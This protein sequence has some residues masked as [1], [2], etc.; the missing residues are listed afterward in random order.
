M[1]VILN[2]CFGGFHPSTECYELYCKK[3]D[4]SC[5][6][7]DYDWKHHDYV[8]VTE[9]NSLVRYDC[10]TKDFGPFIEGSSDFDS[11]IINLFE[12]HRTD[13]ILIECVEEL[14]EQA[15]SAVSKLVVVEIPDDMDYV[16]DNYDG[17]ETLHENVRTW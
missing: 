10:V 6:W 11:H 2:K 17:I 9:F 12:D 5:Y 4:L 1:K 3:K 15:S 13:P 16:I 8:K 14:K 7:Y